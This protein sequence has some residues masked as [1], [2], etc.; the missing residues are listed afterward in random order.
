MQLPKD[1]NDYLRSRASELSERILR[2]YPPLHGVDEPPSPLTGQLLRKPFPAQTL[3]MIGV[4]VS[5]RR[6]P[7]SRL[8]FKWRLLGE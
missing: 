3:A 6:Q 1:I 8:A 4:V 2:M 7:S 5:R